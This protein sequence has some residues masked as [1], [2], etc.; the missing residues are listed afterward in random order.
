MLRSQ[1]KDEYARLQGADRKFV[2]FN[3]FAV[4]L[5]T[6]HLMERKRSCI[7]LFDE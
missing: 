6:A 5:D 2:L 3:I 7:V 4:K 1:I